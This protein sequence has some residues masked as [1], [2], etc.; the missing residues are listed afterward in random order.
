MYLNLFTLEPNLI[1][2]IGTQTLC[3]RV[4]S[5][6]ICVSLLMPSYCTH[7][8]YCSFH[9]APNSSLPMSII[10]NDTHATHLPLMQ[11]F[12]TLSTEFVSFQ[13]MYHDS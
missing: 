12:S 5:P 11:P 9:H 2:L 13:P 7:T 10:L 8:H 6:Y 1:A 4:S 3:V